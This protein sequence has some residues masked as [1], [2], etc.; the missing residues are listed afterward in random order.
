MF[1][2]H[3]F[4]E[5]FNKQSYE[6]KVYDMIHVICF[7][8][9]ILGSF[10]I[11]F[12]FNNKTVLYIT[13]GMTIFFIISMLEGNRTQN[14]KFVSIILVIFFNFFYFPFIFSSYGKMVCILPL[15][16]LFGIVYTI[17]VLDFKLG[18][19]MSILEAIFYSMYI[20]FH[21]FK[22]IEGFNSLNENEI[23]ILYFATI[24]SFLLVSI[25][26]GIALKIKY[27]L[28]QNEKNRAYQLSESAYQEFVSKDM[29][30]L[31][32]SHEIRTP[33]NAIVGNANLILDETRDIKV[34]DSIYNILNSCNA[35]LFVLNDLMDLSKLEEKQI[36]LDNA[37]Y[38]LKN[39]VNDIINVMSIKLME[40]NLSFGVDINC[41]IPRYLIGDVLKVQQIIIGLLE[42]SI[43]NTESGNID[44][45]LN[46]HYVDK[47]TIL[48]KGEINVKNHKYDK[49]VFLNLF[50]H[51]DEYFVMNDDAL[52]RV[53]LCKKLVK[54]MLGELRT[55]FTED[56]NAKIVFEI[57]Q[58]YCKEGFIIDEV[59]NEY[60]VIIIENNNNSSNAL[61][62]IFDNLNVK[63]NILNS[64]D[65]LNNML[66]TGQYTHV[67]ISYERYEECSYYL[68]KYMDQCKIAVI[69][70]IGEVID[71]DAVNYTLVRPINIINVSSI[72]NEEFNN[73]V[74]AKKC[75]TSL[76]LSGKNV[77]IVDDNF[78]NLDV[79]SAIFKKY[80]A[81]IYTA[82][83]GNEAIR[84][85]K[86]QDIDMIFLDYMMPELNGIDTLKIIR[87]LPENKY[88]TMPIFAL[89]ANVISGAYEMFS[90]AG[91]NGFIPK[92]IDLEK[93]EKTLIDCGLSN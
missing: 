48:L 23:R 2:V 8:A 14:K 71:A 65:E 74:Y 34:R 17:L 82:S 41:K 80:N 92:P 61:K 25:C 55:E 3:N 32:V 11:D 79:A 21:Q 35:L 31:N 91:F 83:S 20:L 4:L 52:Y 6:Q 57:Y 18:L 33:M 29:F 40:S 10:L 86:I 7:F 93:L 28:Y 63:N 50:N 67:F 88:S 15:Y 90:Q 89:S 22:Y 45:S 27:R 24:F 70:G 84:M 56:N 19:I 37:K 77:L 66:E 1:I 73:T 43:K 64:V 16:F 51:D 42:Y 5:N 9:M 13:C 49:D 12:F 53:L 46:N 30:L 75:N 62:N 38:D 59:K 39:T 85:L 36:L 72:L 69:T 44:F 76:D 26:I 60:N 81:N 54:L 47:N 68:H 78:T 87:K 58:E